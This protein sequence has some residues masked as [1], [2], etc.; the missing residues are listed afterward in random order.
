MIKS[1]EQDRL[2]CNRT[3]LSIVPPRI[4]FSA[5]DNTV[6]FVLQKSPTAYM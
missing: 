2:L 4:E 1:Y 6:L 3:V 5:N